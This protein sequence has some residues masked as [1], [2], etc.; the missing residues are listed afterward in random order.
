MALHELATNAVKHGG[1]SAPGGSVSVSWRLEGGPGGTLR[2]RWAER[3]GPPV[4]GA[5]ARRGFGSRVL[6]ATIRGQLGGEAALS[7]EA[8]GLVC[9]AEVPLGRGHPVGAGAGDHG[10][11]AD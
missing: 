8:S 3:G 1:L 10:T 4:A 6:D 11:A 5:P 9:D 7:W 2:L